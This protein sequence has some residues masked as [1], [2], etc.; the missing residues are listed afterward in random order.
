M[1]TTRQPL[2]RVGPKNQ[3]REHREDVER[4]RDRE[5]PG[6]VGA[7][8]ARRQV[9][10]R[11]PQLVV[12]DALLDL[13]A[14]A[15]MVLDQ[16]RV[17]RHVGEDEAVAISARRLAGANQRELLLGDRAPPTRA[18]IARQALRAKGHPAHHQAKRLVLPAARGVGGLGNLGIRKVDRRA[19]ASL[20]DPRKR[21]PHRRAARHR[22][23]EADAP[24][25][26]H[27]QQLDP[28]D[29][30]QLPERLLDP[31]R[32]RTLIARDG[33]RGRY[34]SLHGGSPFNLADRPERC[35]RQ[36][37]EREDRRLQVLRA[38]GQPPT[39]AARIALMRATHVAAP[40]VV[41]PAPDVAMNPV[42]AIDRTRYRR[43]AQVPSRRSRD[44]AASATWQHHVP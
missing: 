5:Q 12:L 20:I 23:R 31:W 7:Q 43:R 6:A 42:H 4:D 11:D 1:A 8:V 37:T 24:P 33:L 38:T 25:A 26:Q 29:A 36:R 9:P 44:C 27:P 28:V 10:Q 17:A 34:V 2:I 13:G 21:L 14:V 16:L 32:Q 40:A 35:Q 22:D 18:R 15:V 39:G 3:I 19:P 30:H 41:A